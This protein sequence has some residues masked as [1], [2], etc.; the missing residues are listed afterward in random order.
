MYRSKETEKK[1]A[2][3][4]VSYRNASKFF[5]T[6]GITGADDSGTIDLYAGEIRRYLDCL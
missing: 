2:L 4:K 6:R 5:D 3:S 1:E